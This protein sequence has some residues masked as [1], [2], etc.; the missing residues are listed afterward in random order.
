M[1]Y[2]TAVSHCACAT[3]VLLV[4][5]ST[6]LFDGMSKAGFGSVTPFSDP[7]FRGA[8]RDFAAHSRTLHR[9]KWISRIA[10]QSGMQIDMGENGLLE[11]LADH[12]AVAAAENLP[13]QPAAAAYTAELMDPDAVL[14]VAPTLVGPHVGGLWLDEP[15]INSEQDLNALEACLRVHRE[16]VVRCSTRISLID[17]DGDGVVAVSENQ[18]RHRADFVAACTGLSA[19]PIEALTTPEL[20]R[21]GETP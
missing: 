3:D 8:A 16:I 14:N 12:G 15:W 2:R 6:N 21:C 17:S 7:F 18:D 10:G 11:L 1:C 9:H 20:S 4:E 5:S 19:R 13:G